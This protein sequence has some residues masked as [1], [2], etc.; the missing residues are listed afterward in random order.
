MRGDLVNNYDAALLDAGQRGVV[1]RVGELEA[2]LQAS[3]ATINVD[4]MLLSNMAKSH[5][6]MTYYKALDANLRMIAERQYHARRQLVDATIH[7]GYE[8]EILNAALSPDG[9]GLT[10]YGQI[11]LQL[12]DMAIEDRASVLR[13]NA[14]KFYERYDLGR[15]GSE[16]QSGWRSVWTDRARLGIAHLAPEVTPAVGSQTLADL[17]MF[18]GPSRDDDRFIEV[19]IYGELSWQAL[20]QVVLEKPLTETQDRDDWEFGRQKLGRRG[21]TI[22]DQVNP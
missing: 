22:V 14:F 10:S 16:E 1:P 2:L 4:P 17:I 18:S 20:S 15:A 9:R 6:Y 3:I 19:H 7:T 5:N 8:K 12:Q 11:T 21:V 13:E